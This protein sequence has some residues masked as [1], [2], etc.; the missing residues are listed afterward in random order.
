MGRLGNLCG[1]VPDGCRDPD[2]SSLNSTSAGESDVEAALS[3]DDAASEPCSP[4]FTASPPANGVVSR[5][6]FFE[7][8][9]SMAVLGALYR[10]SVW[11]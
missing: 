4:R 9:L 6:F 2:V 5:G 1:W 3:D 8:K 10:L 11:S 7:L